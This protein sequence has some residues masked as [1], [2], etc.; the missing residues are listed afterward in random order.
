MFCPDNFLYD[1]NHFP[2]TIYI[3][4]LYNGT[5]V[6]LSLPSRFIESATPQFNNPHTRTLIKLTRRDVLRINQIRINTKVPTHALAT[7]M[8]IRRSH[9]RTSYII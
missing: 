6:V 4:T 3:V 2:H 9:L 1:F 5:T 8:R 7:L